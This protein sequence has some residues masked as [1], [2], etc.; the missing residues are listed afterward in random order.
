MDAIGRMVA[1]EG[2]SRPDQ[3]QPIGRSVSSI[4]VGTAPAGGGPPLK[5]GDIL[6]REKNQ[7]ITG[8]G[9]ECLPCHQTAL[10]PSVGEVDV[11]H[12][13]DEFDITTDLYV[14][15]MKF[16]SRP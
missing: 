3:F 6:R 13:G 1:A 8:V 9:V 16:I 7:D 5:P 10:G 14:Q 12:S 2:V 15:K 11:N 4:N